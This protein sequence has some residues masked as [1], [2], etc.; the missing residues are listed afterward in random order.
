MTD[1]EITVSRIKLGFINPESSYDTTYCLKKEHIIQ[2][3]SIYSQEESRYQGAMTEG[4]IKAS[5]K[6][7]G[8]YKPIKR[9]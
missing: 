5:Q 9:N 8:S 3:L 6:K 7:N 4:E 1:D 2:D